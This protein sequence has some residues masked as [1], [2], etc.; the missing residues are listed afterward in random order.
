MRKCRGGGAPPLLQPVEKGRAF[1]GGRVIAGWSFPAYL[2][3]KNSPLDL[4]QFSLLPQRLNSV[5]QPPQVNE[6]GGVGPSGPAAGDPVIFN[7]RA[8]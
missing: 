3:G 6:A 2:R 8:K 5:R 7:A 1:S 4:L